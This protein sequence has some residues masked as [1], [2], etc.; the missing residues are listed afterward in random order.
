[1]GALEHDPCS[2]SRV[3]VEQPLPCSSPGIS[4]RCNE[5]DHQGSAGPL[6]SAT[7]GQASPVSC[8]RLAAHRV[9]SFKQHTERGSSAESL[10]G[11]RTP[12]ACS[13]VSGLLAEIARVASPGRGGKGGRALPLAASPAFVYQLGCRGAS[14]PGSPS[15]AQEAS[16]AETPIERLLSPPHL[17][18]QAASALVTSQ[19]V[20]QPAA[21]AA[22][23]AT[24]DA[25]QPSD[26]F[27]QACSRV[28]AELRNFA[29][30]EQQAAAGLAARVERDMARLFA[31][32][33]QAAS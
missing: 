4:R 20:A 3:E 16:A 28:L 1:M 21:A 19:Q 5:P 8:W 9:A 30:L 10:E 2:S 12:T 15:A 23:A 18:S 24:M 22:A 25:S 31:L 7:P 17:P 32:P 13:T 14:A 6:Q 33:A 27:Q 29:A 26:T 11:G